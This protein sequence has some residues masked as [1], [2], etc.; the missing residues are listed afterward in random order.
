M[1]TFRP[2][3][4]QLYT[5]WQIK[6]PEAPE[7]TFMWGYGVFESIRGISVL[8]HVP[9]CPTP[10]PAGTEIAFL[11]RC[12]VVVKTWSASVAKLKYIFRA[13]L[14]LRAESSQHTGS[15]D[16]DN[17]NYYVKTSRGLIWSGG[18]RLWL[19]DDSMQVLSLKS[20]NFSILLILGKFMQVIF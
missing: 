15:H 9:F 18:I 14:G 5:F 11:Y 16:I 1:K 4:I 6:G 20:S 13:S 3:A 12:K 17:R 8:S 7:T 2:V 19:D 10:C